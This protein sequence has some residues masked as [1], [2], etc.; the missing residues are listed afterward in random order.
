MMGGMA[1]ALREPAQARGIERRGA[2]LDAAIRLLARQGARAVTLRAVAEEAGATHG[3][4]RYYFA[5]REALLDEALKRLA[6]R[7]VEEVERLLS[8][9]ADS[10]PKGGAARLAA[11]LAGPLAGDR[12]ATIARYELFLEAARRP[13]LRPALKAWGAAYERLLA[14][15]MT[16][17]RPDP[18]ADA[19]LLLN[20]LNGLLL[21]Q[22]ALPR[23]D[24]EAAVLRPAIERFSS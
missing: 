2:L 21:R 1:T 10:D 12:D 16:A 14:T 22:A 6:A 19:E 11:H 5:T 7:Q 23:R 8:E 15:Q 24:F 4:P 18:E 13:Q 3:A 9:H 20:L 17:D